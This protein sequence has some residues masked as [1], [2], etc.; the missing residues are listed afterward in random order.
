MTAGGLKFPILSISLMR[1]ATAFAANGL[2]IATV[3]PYLAEIAGED[4]MVLGGALTVVTLSGILV[5][6]RWFS[7]L[8][9]GVPLG[10]LSDRLGRRCPSRLE[11]PDV[12]SAVPHARSTPLPPRSSGCRCCSSPPWE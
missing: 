4:E 8:G 2:A 3:A 11:W 1:F 6:F 12:R 10:H 9:L 7:D 5:G